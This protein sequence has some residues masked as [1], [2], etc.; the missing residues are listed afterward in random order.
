MLK[1]DLGDMVIHRIVEYQSSEFEPLRFFPE[2][3]PEDWAYHKAWMQPHAMDP[4]SGNLILIMQAYLVRTRRHTILVDTCVGDYK[5]RPHRPSWHMQARGTVPAN[6]TAAG[7]HAEQI[8]YV[9]CTHMHTDHVGWNTQL[10]DGRWV[11]TFPNAKYIFSKAELDHWAALPR[12]ETMEHFYDSVLPVVEAG[13]AVLVE[14]DHALDDEVWL[15]STP[16][17]TPDHMSLC[18]ASKGHRAVITGDLIHSPVQCLEPDW[19][20]RADF[21]PEQARYTRRAFLERYCDV[22]VLVCG[23]HFPAPSLGRIVSREDAFW[24]R[25]LGTQ[26]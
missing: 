9:F 10:Q 1:Q 7:V 8:D 5:P 16:G 15:E 3:T 14:N 19:T 6:L 22:D 17:H 2:T 11:P 26:P 12:S 21:D 4:M 24:F 25:F 13:Q 23:S 18:L 20:M